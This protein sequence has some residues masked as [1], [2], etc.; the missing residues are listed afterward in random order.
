MCILETKEE[1]PLTNEGHLHRSGKGLRRWR[2]DFEVNFAQRKA[3]VI[4]DVLDGFCDF[5]EGLQQG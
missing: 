1:V 4:E 3:Q 5:L 2:V